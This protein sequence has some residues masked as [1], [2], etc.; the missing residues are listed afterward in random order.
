MTI[1]EALDPVFGEVV[2]D[3]QFTYIGQLIIEDL[4]HRE[5]SDWHRYLVLETVLKLMHVTDPRR[6]V[7]K[8]EHRVL[9]KRYYNKL[10]RDREA[11]VRAF[12]A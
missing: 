5:V 8:T 2:I 7:L 4:L 10:K 12:S 11:V 3:K 1:Q 6:K 9:H